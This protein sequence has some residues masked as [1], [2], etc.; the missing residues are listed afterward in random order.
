MKVLED[1]T[2]KY[3]EMI[4]SFRADNIVKV[5]EV[6]DNLISF[7][8]SY[9]EIEK[10][11]IKNNDERLM[12]DIELLDELVFNLRH[13]YIKIVRVERGEDYEKMEI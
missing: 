8:K 3:Y 2:D 9:F 6:K 4:N 11:M 1:V 5:R 13:E 7:G 12:G 10:R